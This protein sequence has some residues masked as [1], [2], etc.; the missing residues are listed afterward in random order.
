MITWLSSRHTLCTAR[1]PW[2]PERAR[3]QCGRHQGDLAAGRRAR[4][5]RAGGRGAGG[6]T[7]T[8]DSGRG[9]TGS[10]SAGRPHRR[11]R[12][13][14][15]RL[16]RRWPSTNIAQCRVLGRGPARRPGQGQRWRH[17]LGPASRQGHHEP[18]RGR[19]QDPGV[20][21]LQ[22]SS[23]VRLAIVTMTITQW[24]CISCSFRIRGKFVTALG[25][26]WCPDHFLCS[27]DQCRH[28]L[29]DTGFV[30]DQGKL[31]CESCFENYLAPSCARCSKRVKAVRSTLILS[32]SMLITLSLGMSQRHWQ[33]ISPGVLR[34]HL[35]RTPVR[36]QP[37]LL[38]RRAAVLRSWSVELLTFEKKLASYWYFIRLEWAFHHQV[39]RL[40]FPHR[41]RRSLGW[42]DEQQ[43]P[44][45]VLQ[46]LCK[47]LLFW[48]FYIQ[49]NTLLSMKGV[50]EELGR[51]ELLGQRR[52]PDVQKPRSLICKVD[53]VNPIEILFFVLPI[54]AGC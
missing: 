1:E 19:H 18:P 2:K 26:T 36:Q 50:Q 8:T 45:P 20:R 34:V 11:A 52:S 6:R 22:R 37:L 14:C 24:I 28:E 32:R 13:E 29:H 41:G 44:Q 46:L 42:G 16:S 43:L 9:A 4:R 31:Y 5:A 33:A 15:R 21:H 30:E 40:W 27:M 38:G 48:Q 12:V 17:Q 23:P 3:G 25:L 35:L 10:G 49:I 39:F 53:G 7:A 47:I 51:P 54:N